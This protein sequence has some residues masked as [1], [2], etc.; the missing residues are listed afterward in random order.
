MKASIWEFEPSGAEPAAGLS[1]RV[2]ERCSPP[3][4]EMLGAGLSVRL[5]GAWRAGQAREVCGVLADHTR[6]VG[7]G[8]R[9]GA[10]RLGAAALYRDRGAGELYVI[11]VDPAPGVGGSAWP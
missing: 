8:G 9:W 1:L 3:W 6:R 4:A 7:G 11:A 2:W 10:L 5:G